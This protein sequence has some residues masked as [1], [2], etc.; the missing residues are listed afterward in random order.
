MRFERVHHR[1]PND[2]RPER[3]E[4]DRGLLLPQRSVSIHWHSH[5]FA[6]GFTVISPTPLVK[7]PEKMN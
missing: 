5:F 1:V 4:V 3:D 7:L 2:F 6:R